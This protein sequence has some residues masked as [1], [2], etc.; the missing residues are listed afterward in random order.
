MFFE[1]DYESGGII[2]MHLPSAMF[3]GVLDVLRNEK[4]IHVYLAAS[5]AFLG[6]SDEPIGEDESGP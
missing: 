3:H 1:D 5:R 6:T 4:P 2:R